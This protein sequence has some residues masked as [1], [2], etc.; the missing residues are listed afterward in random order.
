[1]IEADDNLGMHKDYQIFDL[2]LNIV[3]R[4]EMFLGKH[5]TGLITLA[6]FTK[7]VE[8]AYESD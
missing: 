7:I 5:G 6:E 1:M 3:P 4:G 2:L 8:M